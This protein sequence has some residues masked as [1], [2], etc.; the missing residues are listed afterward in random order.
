MTPYP[1]N[2]LPLQGI[3]VIELG[4]IIAGPFAGSLLAEMGATVIKIEQPIVGDGLRQSG[5]KINGIPIWWG[6]ASR[7]KKC[8]SLNLKNPLGIDV[9]KQLIQKADV[10]IENYRPGVLD[11]LGIGTSTLHALVPKLIILSISGYGQDGSYATKPGFGKIAEGLS[12]IVPLTGHPNEPPL[13]TGFSLA[14]ASSGLYGSFMINMLL[15]D[16]HR[17]DIHID[18]ALYEP[19]L[20]MLAFQFYSSSSAPIRQGTNNPHGWGILENPIAYPAFQSIDNHWFL[21]KMDPLSR[22]ALANQFNLFTDMHLGNAIRDWSASN[23]TEEIFSLLGNLGIDASIV[24]NG[25]TLAS[26]AYFK[27]RGDVIQANHPSLGQ[28]PV[29]GFFPKLERSSQNTA[30]RAPQIGEDN[31]FVFKEFLNFDDHQYELLINQQVI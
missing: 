11:K 29:P 3:I 20:E 8:I 17:K 27:S 7:N 14:D 13:Y 28:F 23:T 19:L 16:N 1:N 25:E 24:Q 18:L 6:V 5:P 22:S 12:G 15:L 4:T 26:N 21:I 2:T 10:L 9:F 30:F 31:A